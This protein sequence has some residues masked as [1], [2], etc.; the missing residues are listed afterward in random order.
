M[1]EGECL[2]GDSELER[3]AENGGRGN[4]E[5]GRY[6]TAKSKIM[7]FQIRT[8]AKGFPAMFGFEIS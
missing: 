8:W 3:N 7:K 2:P 1:D 5:T 6:E 4:L